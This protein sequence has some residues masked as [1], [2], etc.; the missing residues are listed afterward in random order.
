LV[1]FANWFSEFFRK[2]F[3][4]CRASVKKEDWVPEAPESE[5]TGLI[6]SFDLF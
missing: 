6:D 3:F 2:Y 4:K 5:F 1:K